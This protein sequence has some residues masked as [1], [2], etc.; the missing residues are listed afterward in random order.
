MECNWIDGVDVHV[1][2]LDELA[3]PPIEDFDLAVAQGDRHKRPIGVPGHVV[4]F[5]STYQLVRIYLMSNGLYFIHI[6]L[7][8]TLPRSANVCTQSPLFTSN[9][10]NVRSSEHD[11]MVLPVGEYL[12]QL[13]RFVWPKKDCWKRFVS[14]LHSLTALSSFAVT[15]RRSFGWNST[16]FTPDNAEKLH[17]EPRTVGTQ[18]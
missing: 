9:N 16:L 18:T 1:V 10:F 2:Q 15:S 11:A 12:A 14:M 7:P 3:R 6:F 5:K 17:D 4:S 8:R 13:T